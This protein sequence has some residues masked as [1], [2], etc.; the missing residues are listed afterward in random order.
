MKKIITLLLLVA[1]ILMLSSCSSGG[2]GNIA[3]IIDQMNSDYVNFE[4]VEENTWDGWCVV[5]DKNT[6]V[7][8]VILDGFQSTGMTPIYN[9]DGTVK[10]YEE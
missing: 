1:S 6:K 4:I 9:S 10:L 8:Y 7:M 5:Y 2:S 3:D